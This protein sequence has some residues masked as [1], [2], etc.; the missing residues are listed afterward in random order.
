MYSSYSH[1]DITAVKSIKNIWHKEI[2]K[3][4]TVVL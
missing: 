4:Y 2:Y 3:V 1:T